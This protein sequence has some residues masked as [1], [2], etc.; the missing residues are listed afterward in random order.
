MPFRFDIAFSF[1]RPH[2]DKVRE[3]AG[4]VAE[5]LGRE[6][7][8]F[9][10]WYEAEILGDDMDVLLQRFYHEQSLF[11]LADLSEDYAD[12]PW[13][14]AEARA[15]R[16]LRFKLDPARDETQRLR[17]LNA[18]FGPGEVP[19]DLPTSFPLDGI[20]KTAR[21]CADLLLTRLALLRAR[22]ALAEPPKAV[23]PVATPG[24]PAAPPPLVWPMADH[25]GVCAAFGTL[26]TQSAPWSFLPIRGASGTGKSHITKQMLANAIRL[27]GVACGR[28]DFK[29]TTY[30]ESEV[31][32]FTQFLEISL[33]P[34]KEG[35]RLT[36]RFGQILT[37]L[38]GRP[39]PSL[40]IFD[41]YEAA[42]EAREWVDNQLLPHLLRCPWLRVVIAG[43]DVPDPTAAIWLSVARAT[44]PVEPPPPADWLEYGKKNRTDLNLTLA[45]VENACL[46]AKNKAGL[47]S[48]LLGPAT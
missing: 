4:L 48:Q 33:P 13:C 24:W 11:V 44:L 36:D 34:A 8:F 47:L 41:T 45:D 39:A 20:N 18:R 2:R 23:Q 28:Y 16:A 46:W 37:A 27:T 21:E 1:A 7:V 3:I 31:N 12:R 35:Q 40:L 29:G 32:S 30:V 43:Q 26:L 5:K 14:Q 15:I 9:D 38:K 25:T 42:G 22:L 6:R 17:L 19:G 10:E